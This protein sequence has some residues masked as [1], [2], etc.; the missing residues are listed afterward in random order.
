MAGWIQCVLFEEC[1]TNHFLVYVPSI[2]PLLLLLDGHASH[3]NP[4][5]LKLAAEEGVITFCLPPHTTHFL[6]PLDNG[7]FA[8]LKDHWRSECHRFCTQNPRRVLNH[9]SFMQI[10]QKAWVQGTTI[11][12]VTT[13]FCAAGIYPVDKTVVLSQISFETICSPSCSTA[14][15]YVPFCMPSKGSTTRHTPAATNLSQALTF[16]PGEVEGFRERFMES[17]DSRYALWLETFYPA[18]PTPTRGVLA[19]FLQ[20]PTP[21]AQRRVITRC[22]CPH[23]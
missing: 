10:F 5:L 7:A 15:P 20:R 19:T 3:Y 23:K 17:N 22:S 13:C 2:R 12:N 11:A 14:I 9:R 21:P 8:L 1:F 4:T 18:N 16:S 6:Q